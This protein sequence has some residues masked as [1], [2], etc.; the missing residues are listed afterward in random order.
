MLLLHLIIVHACA[1]SQAFQLDTLHHGKETGIRGLSV[2]DD[3]VAY[4]SGSNG[5]VGKTVNKGKRWKWYQVP[6]HAKTDFRDIFVFNKKEAIIISAGSPLVI[7]K[8]RNGGKS[9]EE[10]HRDERV[11]IFFDGMDFWD[12][13]RG[14]AY[15][16]PISGKMQLLVTNDGGSTWEDISGTANLMLREG[17]A[18]FA[19]SGT[20]IRTLP[21]GRV[22]TVTGGSQSRIFSSADYGRSWKA[23]PVPIRQGSPSTGIFSIAFADERTGIAVGGDYQDD[24]NTESAVLLT[25][26]GGI[27]WHEPAVGTNGYRSAVESIGDGAWVATGTSGVDVSTDNGKTWT[28]VSKESFHAVRKA[29]NGSWVLLAGSDGRIAGFER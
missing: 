18:G 7:L 5:W 23:Y 25:T 13:R 24:G 4:V 1:F 21:G 9:W 14:I 11:E 2:L 22:F 27:T 20:G 28:P 12:E 17:E 8:T 15:G 16:D 6:G 29:K 26:N 3:K 10:V 19:A